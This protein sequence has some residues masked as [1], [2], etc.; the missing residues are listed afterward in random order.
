M[1]Q[2]LP[3]YAFQQMCLLSYFPYAL[4]SCGYIS[5]KTP[6]QPTVNLLQ[7]HAI[8]LF[9]KDGLSY[10]FLKTGRASLFIKA[11]SSIDLE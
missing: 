11:F 7:S 2:L 5:A 8:S 3:S 4:G 1:H 10:T 6:I 9:E